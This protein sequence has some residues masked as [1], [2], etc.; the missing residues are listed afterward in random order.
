VVFVALFWVVAVGTSTLSAVNEREL[1]RRR[2]DLEALSKLAGRLDESSGVDDVA[3]VLLESVVDTFGLS[4]GV[5]LL[6]DDEHCLTVLATAGAGETQQR[7]T[8]ALP[9]S[10][11]T[12]AQRGVRLVT[13]LDPVADYWLAG[14]VPQ[15]RNL[16]VVPLHAEGPHLGMLVCEHGMRSGLAHRA[17]RR[18]HGRAVRQP[19][20]PRAREH[21]ARRAAAARGR[22][23]RRAHRHR[24]PPDV[25]HRAHPG[26][27]PRRPHRPAGHVV[28]LDL[29]HFKKLNDE[30]GHQMGDEMLRRGRGAAGRRA[31]GAPTPSPATAARSSS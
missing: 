24:Q 16:V 8:R 12:S 27:R 4:R 26:A 18:R 1:R 9:A 20:R 3:R 10:V 7:G 13:G 6:A 31:A 21:P 19:R 14:L 22:R 28:L 2:Y 23:H 30:H 17:A 11:L 5:V 29:D 25:R 15:A